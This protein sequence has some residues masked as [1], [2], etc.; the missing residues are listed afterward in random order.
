V[1]DV[2]SFGHV[3]RKDQP[4]VLAAGDRRDG[5]RVV[6]EDLHPVTEKRSG[7]DLDPIR[8][9]EDAVVADLDTGADDDL[10]VPEVLATQDPAAD[11]S[12]TEADAVPGAV[13]RAPGRRPKPIIRR[14][15]R[16][17]LERGPGPR[18][19]RMEVVGPLEA[20]QEAPP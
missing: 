20:S 9:A 12:V 4:R 6:V 11:T 13:V 8:R 14:D 1:V 16:T 10:P 7:S 18:D 2:L 5:M 3:G 17:H 19:A 15:G